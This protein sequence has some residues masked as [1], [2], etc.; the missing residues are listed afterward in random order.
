MSR[1][2]I[3]VS[4][5]F[6]LFFI[7]LYPVSA[8][9]QTVIIEMT[10]EGFKPQ[11]VTLDSNSAVIFVNKD[12]KDHWPASDI[13]P[14]HEIY[15]EFDPK[16]GIGPK[17][18][19]AFRPKAGEWRFHDHLFPHFNGKLIVTPEKG[20][21]S[22]NG[23]NLVTGFKKILDNILNKV[24]LVFGG[25]KVQVL[26]KEDFVKLNPQDQFKA[27]RDLSSAKGG[28]EAW[29]YIKE[30]YK[31]Q[32]G[33]SGNIHD[34]AHL[35]GGLIYDSKG[36]EGIRSCS[37]D[38]GFG[39]FHG[40]LDKVFVKS[41]DKLQ[42]A[43]QACLKL[44][45][46]LS[47]PVASCIH[48]IGHGVAS[49]YSVSDLKKSLSTCRKL[50]S[51][52]EYCFD[53]VL[54]EF[55]RNAPESYVK[56]ADPLYPCDNLEKEFGY[57]YSSACGRNQPA[58]LLSRFKMNFEQ[59][60]PVCLSSN[61]TPFKQSCIDSLGFSLAASQDTDKI[62]QGCRLFGEAGYVSRCIQAA[63]GELVFQD[64]PNWEQKSKIVCES[65]PDLDQCLA[66]VNKLAQD[67]K[68]GR[69]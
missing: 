40:F 9:S 39:C 4:I 14:T 65:T 67:Y 36:F 7:S 6:V 27:L 34:L 19:W 42:D 64:V 61:S 53:G 20:I 69:K 44:D 37:T 15:P 54:M 48:G 32:A 2:K 68:R 29:E 8:H 56:T 33:S 25:S 18:S 5:L 47:G 66:Y 59:V 17:G 57:V 46:N 63:A 28:L 52:S 11:E 60:I 62:I 58:L 13:H 21:I 16:K 51:G 30:I 22:N 24:R 55:A 50:E 1:L 35:A 3:R 41:I 43:H 12:T 45:T 38:F 10:A 31:G 23:I 49:F 26:A